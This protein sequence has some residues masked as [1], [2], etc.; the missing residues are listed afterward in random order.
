MQPVLITGGAGYIGSHTAHQL[1]QAGIPVV[2]L[3]NFSTG[4]PEAVEGLAVYQGDVADTDLVQEI[5]KRHGIGSVIHFAGKSIVSESVSNPNV[6]YYANTS[7]SFTL[8]HSLIQAGV[9]KIVFSSTAAV[10]GNPMTVPIQEQFPT[11]PVNPYGQSKLMVEEYLRLL[12]REYSLKW[13]A[14]RYFNAAGA[15]IDGSLGEDH[16]PETHLI[17]QV[18]QAALGMKEFMPVYGGDYDTPDGTCVR[19][20]VHVLDLAEAHRT[21]L[22]SLD[23]GASGC[24]FN[25]GTG[26]GISVTEI[27]SAAAE[28][29]G[30]IIPVRM[31]GR[32]DGDPAALVADSRLI[33]EELGWKPQYSDLYTILDSAWRWHRKHPCGYAARSKP[34]RGGE[35][36]LAVL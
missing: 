32:R 14:L 17:P 23:R 8:F 15:A 3:D 36:R 6:Y 2:V 4:H 33:R 27:L 1:N 29:T 16:S 7:K 31:C 11:F 19:D 21:A 20:Y 25:V 22:E 9:K 13:I 12:G 10:Y 35:K 18:L 30:Q 34:G 5:V 28:V 24:C 26:C